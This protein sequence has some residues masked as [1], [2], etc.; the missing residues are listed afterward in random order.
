MAVQINA[1]G[2]NLNSDTG[3]GAY[4]SF[5]V[6]CWLRYDTLNREQGPWFFHDGGSTYFGLYT[7]SSGNVVNINGYASDPIYTA[8]GAWQFVV[9]EKDTNTTRT[10]YA[11]EGATSVTTSVTSTGWGTTYTPVHLCI[12]GW[13]YYGVNSVCTIAHFRMWSSALTTGELNAELV[14]PTAVKTSGLTR[15]YR[16]ET[17]AL[18]TDS[19]GLGRTLDS[20]GSPT[21]VTDPTFPT[22]S[23]RTVDRAVRPAG[24]RINSNFY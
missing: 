8:A 6:A 18:T 23:G 17:G 12:G 15:E 14:S 21:F 19:S 10:F 3:H 11:A 5:T 9:V 16:F 7:G 24:A 20:Y 22:A 4:T 13:D 2:E 1:G